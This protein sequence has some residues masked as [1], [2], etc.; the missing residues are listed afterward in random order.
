MCQLRN[1]SLTHCNVHHVASA[2]EGNLIVLC[3]RTTSIGRRSF[4][5]SAPVIWNSLPLHLQSP[6]ICHR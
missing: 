4:T 6:S 2:N 1:Y 3:T 5:F